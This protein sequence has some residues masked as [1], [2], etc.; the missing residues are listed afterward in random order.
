[1]ILHW[2]MEMLQLTISKIWN[3]RVQEE[4]NKIRHRLSQQ[5]ETTRCV[6][7]IPSL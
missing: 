1:M 5:L 7:E 3:T 4:E 2:N 6:S